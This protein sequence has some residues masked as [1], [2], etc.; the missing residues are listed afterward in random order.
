M[1]WRESNKRRLA[2]QILSVLLAVILINIISPIHAGASKKKSKELA[3][4]KRKLGKERHKVRKLRRKEHS[5]LLAINRLNRGIFSSGKELSKLK[6]SMKRLEVKKKA[7]EKKLVRIKRDTE[8]ERDRAAVRLRAMYKMRSGEIIAMAFAPGARDPIDIARRHKYMTVITD[9]DAA[10]LSRY[11]AQLKARRIELDRLSVLNRDLKKASARMLSK[12]REKKRLKREKVALLADVRK[13]KASGL[14]VL[15][16]L[17]EAARELS[18]LIAQLDKGTAGSASGFGAMK[19]RLA[20]P[21][22]GRIK[23]HY[24]KVRHRKFKTITFNKGIVISAPVGRKVKSVYAGRVIYSGW[25]KGYGQLVILDHG[26]GF[27]TLFAYLDRVLKK[28]GEKVARGDTVAT[29]GD[30]GPYSEP[31]LYFEIRKRGVPQDPAKWLAR[32]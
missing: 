13:E 12:K 31:G 15:N 24:G 3:D 28:R 1:K 18:T 25:L 26:G 27:Y 11:E 6:S 16:E 14:K 17:E 23:S 10:I 9:Y 21:V 32:R 19:G 22:T 4:V 29:V 30:T 8:R 20:M 2:G 7:V 5:I